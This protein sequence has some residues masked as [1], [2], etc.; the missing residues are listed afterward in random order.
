MLMAGGGMRGGQVIGSSDAIG[1]EPK[2]RPVTPADCGHN[3]PWVGDSAGSDICGSGD[4][5]DPRAIRLVDGFFG[6]ERGRLGY[7]VF[8]RADE[9]EQRRGHEGG[10]QGH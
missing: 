4:T 9:R 6:D 3:R 7:E 2:D 8:W 1:A 5:A 10:D